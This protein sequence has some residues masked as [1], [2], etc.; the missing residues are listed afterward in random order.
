MSTHVLMQTD[1]HCCNS[2]EEVR[3]AYRKKGWA[4]SN[5]DL[6]DQ[7]G[8]ILFFYYTVNTGIFCGFKCHTYEA[9]HILFMLFLKHIYYTIY[10]LKNAMRKLTAAM[11]RLHPVAYILCF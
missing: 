5:M 9:G 10:K 11:R 6:I 2:C 3:E 8:L 4:L 7:V 1:D